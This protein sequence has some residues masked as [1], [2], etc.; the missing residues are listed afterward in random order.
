MIMSKKKKKRESRRK[1]HNKKSAPVI[2]SE[3]PVVAPEIKA[4]ILPEPEKEKIL[5]PVVKAEML[6]EPED[7]S[8]D[9]KVLVSEVK[10]DKL[11]DWGSLTISEKLIDF[12]IVIDE[13]IYDRSIEAGIECEEGEV[14]MVYITVKKEEVAQKI[15]E[16]LS[17][18]NF[19]RSKD[20]TT[21]GRIVLRTEGGVE[22]I[23]PI[24]KEA[25]MEVKFH[26]ELLDQTQVL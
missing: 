21:N 26:K 23:V 19:I 16:L 10:T 25:G 9:N 11:S 12:G 5:A 4:E 13:V 7:N 17:D 22:S 14:R 2:L 6:T 15:N 8:K 1:R 3:V 18:L 24:L 20:L